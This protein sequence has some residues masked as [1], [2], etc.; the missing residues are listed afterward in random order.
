MSV[1]QNCSRRFTLISHSAQPQE[2]GATHTLREDC[3]RRSPVLP[4]LNRTAGERHKEGTPRGL[5]PRRRPL[6]CPG[7]PGLPTGHITF[8]T[9]VLPHSRPRQDFAFFKRPLTP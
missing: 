7:V 4:D 2:V 3:S 5:A 9:K 8:G 6:H 1:R